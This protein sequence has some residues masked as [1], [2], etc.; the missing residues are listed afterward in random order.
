MTIELG[1]SVLALTGESLPE[2]DLVGGKAW[3]IARM[4]YLGLPVPPAFTITTEACHTYL[5]AGQLDE[6][7]V[8]D[9]RAGIDWLADQTRRQFDADES[10]LLVSV[11]SGAPISMPGMM[12]TVLNLG[13]TDS[14]EQALARESNNPE[15]AKDTHRRFLE[16]F[17][18]I[19]HKA[20]LADLDPGANSADW[21][22]QIHRAIGKPLSTDPYVQLNEAIEAVFSSWNSRRA[23]RYRKHNNIPDDLGT[24]VTV[25]AMVFGNLDDASGTGVVFS[26]NPLTGSPE[27]YGEY[28]HCAQGEDVVS[29]KF[30]PEPLSAM[31]QSVTEA[32]RQLLE[33]VDVLERENGD[34]QDIEFTVQRGELFL[35]QTRCRETCA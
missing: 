33:S 24:A 12:D 21:L 14:T 23:K 32:H 7:L 34:V 9:I 20:T 11:R 28:L 8:S 16:L 30:T 13:I 6:Q 22:E 27:P 31:Q 17:P 26:R 25:Q 3:S 4:R 2:R 1:K 18:A 29:G 5:S 10:P 19:V 35:L 15:F